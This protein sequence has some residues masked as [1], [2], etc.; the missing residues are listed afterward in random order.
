M[1]VNVQGYC[2]AC[3][4]QKLHVHSEVGMIHCLNP[5]CPDS[6][7]A[8]KILQDPEV[9]HVVT[10]KGEGSWVTRHPLKER[11]GNQLVECE[12]HDLLVEVVDTCGLEDYVG[13]IRFFKDENDIWQ[14]EAVGD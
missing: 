6:G 2:P 10:F 11:V 5:K 9:E 4:Q 12:V 3:G 14:S 1:L 8:N 7:A 13:Q